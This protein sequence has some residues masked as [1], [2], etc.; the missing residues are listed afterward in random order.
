MRLALGYA[1]RHATS[2][3]ERGWYATGLLLPLWTRVGG[4]D[5]L[6]ELTG[7]T[8]ATLSGYNTGRLRLGEK[9]AQKI[10]DALEITLADLGC[11][12][13]ADGDLPPRELLAQVLSRME[14][15]E[16]RV[17]ALER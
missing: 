10:A 5:R 4:R 8:G 17:A 7:I 2:R 14:R 9:N 16:S 13:D 12:D 11:P 3:M 15:L 6:A 1:I